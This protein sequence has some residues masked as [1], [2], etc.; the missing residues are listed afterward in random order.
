VQD[1]QLNDIFK[2]RKIGKI[3]NCPYY[4]LKV[5]CVSNLK[6]NIPTSYSR[7]LNLLGIRVNKRVEY[8]FVCF[9]YF[10]SYTFHPVVHVLVY[11]LLGQI[12]NSV[13]EE[14]YDEHSLRLSTGD[15]N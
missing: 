15:R 11:G 4:S 6:E 12:E 2:D 5:T 9:H 13:G 3:T 8:L 10:S 1:S 7:I 14:R